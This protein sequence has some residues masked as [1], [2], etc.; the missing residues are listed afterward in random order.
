MMKRFFYSIGMILA[1]VLAATEAQAFCRPAPHGGATGDPHFVF[2]AKQNA[3][4]GGGASMGIYCISAVKVKW[5]NMRQGVAVENFH[6]KLDALFNEI[7]VTNRELGTQIMIYKADD[8]GNP[9]QHMTMDFGRPNT[10]D[11]KVNGSSNA[12][13]TLPSGR[14]VVNAFASIN[15]GGRLQATNSTLTRNDV[16]PIV[17]IGGVE[18]TYAIDYENDDKLPPAGKCIVDFD[19]RIKS[20]SSASKPHS[21]GTA[22]KDELS[23]GRTLTSHVPM[24][25]YRNISGDSTTCKSGYLYLTTRYEPWE[26]V[27]GSVLGNEIQLENGTSIFVNYEVGGTKLPADLTG[28]REQ[29]VIVDGD[30]MG[31]QDELSLWKLLL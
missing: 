8:F 28:G 2:H 26:G 25:F 24:E 4:G 10:N 3:V 21:L 1:I 23:S 22:S 30:I 12:G 14:Y 13:D 16:R 7:E 17:T 19:M 18:V 29:R 15:L 5:H 31:Y 9:I 20:G 11:Y 27:Q 6:T